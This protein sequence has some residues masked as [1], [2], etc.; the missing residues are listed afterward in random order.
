MFNVSK[1]EEGIMI[2]K[3][4]I[5]TDEGLVHVLEVYLST[6]PDQGHRH[7]LARRGG[8]CIHV[9]L[10]RQYFLLSPCAL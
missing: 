4:R 2:E 1:D 3:G 5:G 7:A 9:I 8:F 6:D 10:A